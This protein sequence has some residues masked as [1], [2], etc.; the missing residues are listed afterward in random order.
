MSVAFFA[1]VLA[2]DFD[3]AAV[4]LVG[5]FD[6][7]VPAFAFF[8]VA[9]GFATVVFG[10]VGEGVDF[11]EALALVFLVGVAAGF[12]FPK[13]L[14]LLPKSWPNDT[15]AKPVSSVNSIAILLTPYINQSPSLP[16]RRQAEA[17]FLVSPADLYRCP[18]SCCDCKRSRRF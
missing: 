6:A 16:L 14:L 3:E 15:T 9:F 4:G 10:F 13:S 2:V 17:E 5:D 12:D 7:D 18:K 1:V 11:A 8:T